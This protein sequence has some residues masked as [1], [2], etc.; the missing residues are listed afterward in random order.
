VHPPTVKTLRVTDPRIKIPAR[1]VQPRKQLIFPIG[2]TPP[3]T[4]CSIH[5]QGFTDDHLAD[6]ADQLFQFPFKPSIGYL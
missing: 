1:A 2:Q 5:F 4:L 3:A 6:R